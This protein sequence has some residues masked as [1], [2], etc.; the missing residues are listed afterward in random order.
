MDDSLPLHKGCTQMVA[1]R[2]GFLTGTNH[3]RSPIKRAGA[4]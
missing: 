3:L 4:S 2:V 1:G